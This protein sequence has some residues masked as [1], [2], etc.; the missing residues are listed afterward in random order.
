MQG[1]SGFAKVVKV[2]RVSWRFSQVLQK[3]FTNLSVISKF[4]HGSPRFAEVRP[5]SPRFAKVRPG[6]PSFAKLRYDSV[7]TTHTSRHTFP[8][9]C[10]SQVCLIRRLED[11]ALS[12]SVYPKRVTFLSSTMQSYWTQILRQLSQPN[13]ELP[14]LQANSTPQVG[15][16]GRLADQF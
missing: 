14:L 1:S 8:R 5:G 10:C 11:N 6:S 13:Q 9:A 12:V 2:L 4:I 15:S 7:N 16:F 3:Y